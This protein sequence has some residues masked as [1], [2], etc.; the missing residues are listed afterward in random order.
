MTGK[1][2]C[3]S[4]LSVPGWYLKVYAWWR[5]VQVAGCGEKSP[6]RSLTSR[7]G[8]QWVRCRQSENCPET[9]LEEIKWRSPRSRLLARNNFRLARHPTTKSPSRGRD[10]L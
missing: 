2:A 6:C 8:H 10:P 9:G 7:I 1:L 5:A 4:K 3:G